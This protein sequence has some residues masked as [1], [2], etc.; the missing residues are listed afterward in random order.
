MDL[1]HILGCCRLDLEHILG[2]CRLDLDFIL[3]GCDLDNNR[4]LKRYH[5]ACLLDNCRTY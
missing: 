2:H 4:Y 3:G 1:E 5:L